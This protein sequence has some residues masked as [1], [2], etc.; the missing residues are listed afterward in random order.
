MQH[1]KRMVLVD[2]RFLDN[3]W[4]KE[5]TSWKRTSDDKAKS[6]LNRELKSNLDGTDIPDDIKAKQHQQHLNRFL[7]T[8]RELPVVETP[9]EDLIDFKTVDQLLELEPQK[10]KPKKKKTVTLTVRKSKRKPK[11]I[12]WLS[13]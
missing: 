6:L 2:E 4:R 13:L 10:K 9:K 11:K 3:I 12:N 8:A 7:H 1:A 5:N